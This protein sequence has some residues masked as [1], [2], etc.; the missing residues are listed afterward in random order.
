MTDNLSGWEGAEGVSLC[1]WLAGGSQPQGAAASGNQRLRSSHRALAALWITYGLVIFLT[2]SEFRGEVL[3]VDGE[4]DISQ[5]VARPRVACDRSADR[6]DGGRSWPS[7][8]DHR[9][10]DRSR[11]RQARCDL[12]P[13]GLRH[14]RGL[15]GEGPR[16]PYSAPAGP[17]PDTRTGW[18]TTTTT[19][20]VAVVAWSSTSTAL[21][22]TTPCLTADDD[23]G[24]EIDEAEVVYWGRC[25]ACRTT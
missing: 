7:S 21:S 13:G 23:H 17:S 11:P 9:G 16:A 18:G 14:A 4:G 8:R 25:P 24:F 19:W 20:C 10:T 1:K 2:W 15:R 3:G 12:P 22:A 5:T 6:R